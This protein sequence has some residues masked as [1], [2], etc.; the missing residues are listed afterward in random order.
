MLAEIVAISFLGIF[1]YKWCGEFLQVFLL[2]FGY[3][4]EVGLNILG[5]C[6]LSRARPCVAKLQII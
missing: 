6:T 5:P 4:L 1:L 3:V 2:R